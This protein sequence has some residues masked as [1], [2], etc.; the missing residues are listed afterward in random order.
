MNKFF[1]M[2]VS[3]GFL[4]IAT[5]PNANAKQVTVKVA[6]IFGPS[7]GYG[8]DGF[9]VF[10]SNSKK[11]YFYNGGGEFSVPGDKYIQEGKIICV[12]VESTEGDV[13]FGKSVKKGK[14]K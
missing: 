3:L 8:E 11:Y 1:C 7:E 6:K 12:N 5:L 2:I 13:S 4:T 14:C 9:M 10:S